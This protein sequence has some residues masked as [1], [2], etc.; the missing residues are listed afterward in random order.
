MQYRTE[1]KLQGWRAL[2][3]FED[4]NQCLIYLG[5]STTQVRAGY[6]AAFLEVLDEEERAQV[7]SIS[8]Q[9]WQGAA[10][11]GRWLTKGNL[12]IPTR[13]PTP[14]LARDAAATETDPDMD[15]LP[16]RT[17][18]EAEAAVDARPAPRRK[19]IAPTA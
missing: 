7:R 2:A 16:F 19:Y 6:A 4:G 14:A 15:I 13:K 12:T 17:D 3:V 8:L 10:D 1:A 5:R 18:E 9:C 11:E